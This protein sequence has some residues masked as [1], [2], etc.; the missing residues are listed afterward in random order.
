MA[1]DAVIG[2]VGTVV[3]RIRGAEGPGEVTVEVRGGHETFIAYAE[4]PI[5]V[6][7]S[8]LVL[9]SHGPRAVDVKPWV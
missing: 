1:D 6:H 7:A 4:A 9:R 3:T 2:C 5:E 8:V